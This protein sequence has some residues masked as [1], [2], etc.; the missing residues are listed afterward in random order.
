MQL[1]KNMSHQVS[2]V[3]KHKDVVYQLTVPR[4][5]FT[6]IQADNVSKHCSSTT[7]TEDLS[8]IGL[9]V[10]GHPDE[11]NLGETAVSCKLTG[12]E[13]SSEDGLAEE[14]HTTIFAN[15]QRFMCE[16]YSRSS[17]HTEVNKP[18]F[19][20]FAAGCL[21]EHIPPTEASLLQHVKHAVLCVVGPVP[22]T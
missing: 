22:G 3:Y 17:P 2:T 10:T 6:T 8:G 20:I 11:D 12:D 16:M 18:Q 19:A 5:V 21:I 15:L 7:A 9:S 1:Y 13:T 4:G 14:L